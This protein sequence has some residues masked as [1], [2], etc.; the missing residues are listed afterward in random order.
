MDNFNHEKTYDSV[1]WTGVVRLTPYL[2]PLVNEAFGEHYSEHTIV[3]LL[4]MKQVTKLPDKTL[5][6]READSLAEL[7]DRAAGISR[8][9]HFECETWPDKSIAIRIAE[10]AAGAAF[11]S[12]RLTENGACM[13]VPNSA[14]IVLKNKTPMPEKLCITIRYPGGSVDYFAPLIKMWHYPLDVLLEKR[15]YLLLPF[16][17]IYGMEAK[18]KSSPEE[19]LKG[20]RS[21]MERIGYA[22]SEAGRRGELNVTQIRYLFDLI[23][24][25]LKRL[26][27]NDRS[28]AEGVEKIM[29]GEILE[30]ETDRILERGRTEGRE[31]GR[32]EGREQGRQEG[33]QEGRLEGQND[34]RL[35]IDHMRQQGKSAEDIIAE[36]MKKEA[37][38]AG[39][40]ETYTK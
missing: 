39:T 29:G 9:Y 8:L 27:E 21:D 23:E 16:Y 1:F 25:V 33:R 17:W 5:P 12:I 4:P 20:I 2:V 40:E 3:R 18:E 19:L 38:P 14:V 7:T 37:I 35:Q 34:I 26:S 13:T 32:Q 31:E 11:G 30:L 15:L 36:I 24:Q 10:Y 6:K 28:V 22:F